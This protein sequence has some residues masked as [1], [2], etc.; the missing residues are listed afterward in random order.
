MLPASA[1]APAELERRI[2][3][4]NA[5]LGPLTLEVAEG[6]APGDR[7]RRLEEEL[8][9]ID[10]GLAAAQHGLERARAEGSEASREAGL[11]SVRSGAEQAA[12]HARR[13]EGLLGER[14]RERMRSLMSAE[15]ELLDELRRAAAAVAGVGDA[16]HARAEEAETRV[17]GS[18]DGDAIAEEMK[19]CSAREFEIQAQLKAA[20]DELTR[21]EVEAAHI[22][23]RRG[24][25]AKELAR[26][27]ARLDEEVPPRE[28]R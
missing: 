23:D 2:E 6:G 11:G 25:A 9:A 24:E 20:S 18:D 8:T 5:E 22:G 16:L 4:L 15:T 13:A 3:A 14:H 21:A 1:T 7:A 19:A 10:S 27:A 26:I 17:V 28:R 12:R